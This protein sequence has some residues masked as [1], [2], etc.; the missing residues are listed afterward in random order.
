MRASRLA[1]AALVVVA[2]AAL[3][4]PEPAGAQAGVSI[5]DVGWWTR[6]PGA[7]P[8]PPGGFEVAEA[9]DDDLS[10]AALRMRSTGRATRATLVLDEAGG[11]RQD[12]A[13]LQVCA[14]TT[15][16][17]AS[18][19]GAYEDRPVAN[20]SSGAITLNRTGSS[21]SANVLPLVGSGA[22]TS[23]V[24]LPATPSSGLP[25]DSF[26]ITF[27][28]ARVEAEV[29]DARSGSNPGGTTTPPRPARAVTGSGSDAGFGFGFGGS[30]AE[31]TVLAP[32]FGVPA[33]DEVPASAD[34]GG[35]GV[36][37]PAGDIPRGGEG[38]NDNSP[39]T[40]VAALLLL[41]AVTAAAIASSRRYLAGRG[42][43]TSH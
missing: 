17:S 30:V 22:T 2:A 25:V 27:A 26:Q 6:R 7:S 29:A 5:T 23:L 31:P 15:T 36:G 33:T 43:V 13:S 9:P 18:N 14:T 34:P 28:S 16:W 39:W 8:L 12:M 19:P 42:A 37:A 11:T 3:P 32:D 10:I 4:R 20:C 40:R 24:V 38:G 41:A 1:M 35:E 21:W